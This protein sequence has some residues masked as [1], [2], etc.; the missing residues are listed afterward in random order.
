[1]NLNRI[2]RAVTN[3]RKLV[4]YILFKTA[5]LWPDKIYLKWYFYS[6]VGYKLDLNNPKTFNEKLQWLKLNNRKP[7]MVKMVDKVDAKDRSTVDLVVSFEFSLTLLCKNLGNCSGKRS[8]AMV[9]VT[10]RTHVHVGLGALE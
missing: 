2:I 3:P 10:D 1:M 8:F 4:R 5:R 9:N 6:R 7:E